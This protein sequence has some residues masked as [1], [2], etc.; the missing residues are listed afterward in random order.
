MGARMAGLARIPDEPEW[1]E[2]KS[3]QMEEVCIFIREELNRL[4]LSGSRENFLVAHG[5]ELMGRIKDPR[6]KNLPL[7]FDGKG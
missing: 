2:E 1:A 7:L 5:E 6:I 4:C 3:R